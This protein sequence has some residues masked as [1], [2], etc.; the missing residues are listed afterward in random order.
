MCGGIIFR[1]TPPPTFC[2]S[3]QCD[4]SRKTLH[5]F[6]GGTDG[7]SP[8]SGVTFDS[9][10]N[11]Y[12]TTGGGGG[13]ANCGA[14]GCGTVYEVS[15]SGDSWNER[16]LYAFQGDADGDSPDDGVVLNSASNILGTCCAS[17]SGYPN[18]AVYEL[19]PAGAGYSK[20]VIYSFTGGSGGSWPY[21]LIFDASG[22]LY[23]ATRRGGSGNGGLVYQLVP[24]G[25]GWS[26]VPLYA[27]YDPAGDP[28]IADS[29]TRMPP[30]TS[31]ARPSTEAE[32]N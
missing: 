21:G 15:P 11:L 1:L 17:D 20:S 9:S 8:S 10:G 23:G 4:W 14:G 32:T 26:F 27:L 13:G 29:L 18:G 31:T 5:A 25:G 24:Q 12:G 7:A 30:A 2:R 6:S 3:V 19:T 22:N 28:G 16:V